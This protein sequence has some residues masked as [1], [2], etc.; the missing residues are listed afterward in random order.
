MSRANAGKK[1]TARSSKEAPAEKGA[2]KSGAAARQTKGGAFSPVS[3]DLKPPELE[4]RVLD[5]WEKEKVFETQRTRMKGRKRFVFLEGPPTA[6]GLPHI[7]HALTRAVKDAFLRYKTMTGHEVFPN[8]GGWDCHGLPVEVEVEKQLGLKSK[9]EIETYGLEKFNGKCRESVFKYVDEWRRMSDRLGLWM[10]FD[11]PY[12]TMDDDYIE[13]VW[14]SLKRLHESLLLEKGHYVVHYCPRCGTPLSSHEVAQGYD[15]VTEDSVYVRFRLKDKQDE[16]VLA[17]TTTPWTLPGNVA[18]AVGAGIDYVKARQ[19]DKHGNVEFLYLAKERLDCLK[20]PCEVV[21]ELKGREMEGWEYEPLYRVMPPHALE[22]KRAWFV[23]TADFVTT[24]EGTGVVHTAVMYG[25]DDYKLG[26]KLDLPRFHTV[27]EQG[28]FV[29]EVAKFA[30]QFVKDAEAPITLDLKERG[31]LYRVLKYTHSYPFCWRCDSPLLYYAF[32]S[33]FVRMSQVREWLKENNETVSWKPGH[34]K[35][36]RFGNFLDELKDWALSRNRFWGTPLPLWRCAAGHFASVGSRLELA[37]RLGL[38][39]EGAREQLWRAEAQYHPHRAARVPSA[40]EWTLAFA[41]DNGKEA[42]EAVKAVA[43]RLPE[44]HRPWVDL[45]VFP[46]RECGGEMRREPYVIDCW[47]DSGS[48]PFAQFHYPFEN[49]ETTEASVPVDFITEAIDQTR[50]WFYSLLAISSTVFRRPAYQTVLC[51]GHILDEKGV[52]MS[53]SKGNMVEVRDIM[54]REGADALRLY[55]LGNPVWD[56]VPFSERLVIESM[57]KTYLTLWNVYSFFVSNANLDG[58]RGEREASV[59][60]L[61]RWLLSRL[62]STVSEV[63]EAM[64]AYEVHRAVRS[65]DRFVDELSNWY[66]R[67][68]RRR[69]WEGALAKEKKAAYSTLYRALTALSRLMAPLAPFVAE[70]MHQNL[71][72]ALDPKRTSVHLEPFPEAAAA[73]EDRELGERMGLVIGLAEAGRRARQER[74]VKLRQPL[75]EAVVVGGPEWLRPLLPLLQEELNVKTVKTLPD[76]KDLFERSV[77]PNLS[78]LG[79]MCR[80]DAPKVVE[81][82]KRMDPDGLEEALSKGIVKVEGYDLTGDHVTVKRS[83]RAG[84]AGATVDNV[85]IYLN[86]ELTPDLVSEG[87]ARDFL[88]RVQTTRKEMGLAYDDRIALEVDADAELGAAVKAHLEFVKREA[89]ADEFAFSVSSGNAAQDWEIEGHKARVRVAKLGGG[90]H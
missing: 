77:V 23:T 79:P 46:C 66:L 60:L 61:D 1:S 14:W 30:G 24:T 22:G 71:V 16:S 63:R 10:D 20:G 11:H 19:E 82:V 35:H 59:H 31:L 80:K 26:V 25:E 32:D 3:P 29:P 62:G 9:K 52:K 36:G 75:A 56:S 27:D 86:M 58:Y 64:D 40:S 74:D 85:G 78:A 21:R 39:G 13:S 18:L 45:L 73:D 37:V 41:H 65:L 89:L 54:A 6:N 90:P 7:G 53:K 88:R 55:L 47:Y 81:S 44:L 67:R 17:W 28:R 33:W 38:A 34:L 50:G 83:L 84:F 43:G 51:L 76:S 70:E 49:G 87:L 57:R 72:R 68:S 8:I 48:A 2:P 69:F 4:A 15:E 42:A 5:L 12:V